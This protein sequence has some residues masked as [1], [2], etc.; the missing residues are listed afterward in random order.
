MPASPSVEKLFMASKKAVREEDWVSA[1]EAFDA[2]LKRFPSNNRAKKGMQSLLPNALPAILNIAQDLQRKGEWVDAERHLRI[3]AA[4][5]PGMVDVQ[6]ALAACQLQL[7]QAPAALCTA[8]HVLST[9]P[10]HAEALIFKG[11]AQREM[12]RNQEAE[13][14]FLAAARS[15][16]SAANALNNLGITARARG[17]G[18]AATE[19]YCRALALEPENVELHHNLAQSRPYPTDDDHVDKMRRLATRLS[20]SP[21]AA[22][23]HFALFKTLNEIGQH[24]EAIAY[25]HSANRLARASTAYDFQKDALTFAVSKTLL[26][27]APTFEPAD[28][29]TLRPIFVTGLPRTGTTLVERIMACDEN[30]QASGELS[31]VQLAVG[32]MLRAVMARDKRRVEPG[33]LQALRQDVC[34]GLAAYSNGHRVII[35]KTPLNFRWIGYI[36]A[37]LPEARI[38]H[39]SRDPIPVAWS[40]YRLSFTGPGNGFIYDFDDIAKFMVLHRN[41]MDHWH[42]ILP[43]HVFEQRYETLVS[44][45]E[46]ET[47]TLAQAVGLNWSDAWLHPEKAQTQVLTAST[48]Q[49]RK[50]IYQGSNAGWQH[51]EE[52]LQPMIRKLESAQL[53]PS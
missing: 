38:V 6:L 28:D 52:A 22:P 18:P 46:D 29:M 32:K 16:R 48:D 1:F 45:P 3:A 9:D 49:V 4:L 53:L 20:G 40:L 35:D 43:G 27:H 51:Y 15:D 39:L 24:Q 42:S 26:P 21:E 41:Y 31:V 8:E 19:Y 12:S 2:V 23:L 5:A 37:A 7:G 33:D 50:P 36:C 13:Q 10:V 11:R 34:E 25:L 44:N 14:S 17:D 47:R 30:V